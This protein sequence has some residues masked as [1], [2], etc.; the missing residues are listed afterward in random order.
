MIV[1]SNIEQPILQ[2][3]AEQEFNWRQCWYPVCFVQDLPKNRPYTFSLYDEPF[4]LFPNKEG[5]LICLTDQCSHRAAKLSDGQIIDGKI[6]CLYHGWQFGDQGKCMHIPQLA[7]DAKI[8]NNA[9]VRSFKIVERQ[10]II[11]MWAGEAEIADDSIP[12]IPE[13]EQ[14]GF[15]KLDTMRDLPYDQSYFIENVIDPAHAN[16]SHDGTR[17]G[18]KRENAQPLEMEVVETSSQG[19]RGRFRGTN[20]PNANWTSLDFMA[21]NLIIYK[22]T[23]KQK[24]WIGG[25]AFYSIPLGKGKC[26]VLA[27]NYRNFLTGIDKLL[28]RW[29]EHWNRNQLLEEDFDLIA[30]QQAIV[31]RLGKNLEKLY[32]PLKTSDV[33]VVEYRKWLDKFG[34]GLPYYQG[35]STAKNISSAEVNQQSITLDRLSQH[36]LICSSCNQAY[37]V[38]K[39]LKTTFL[40]VAIGTAALA[41]LADNFWL[42]ISAVSVSFGAIALAILS[43]KVKT[44]FENAHTR[45]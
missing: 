24:G 40:G 21:P 32:L 44:K 20:Q 11:W 19:I 23:I 38:T 13:F 4:V 39:G 45:H 15:V 9:C 37:Q 31:E 42:K 30:G 6:E 41:I 33:L 27:R 8:P 3:Q 16:I 1:D 43:Q 34:A 28:P 35:Y 5:Q 29:F 18:G 26:R 22:F 10:G 17:N 2:S 36:T 7:K 14:A 12:I 25:L